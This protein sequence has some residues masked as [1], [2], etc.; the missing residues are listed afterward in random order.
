MV[1]DA[2]GLEAILR[3]VIVSCRSCSISRPYFSGTSIEGP[4]Y[5]GRRP[6]IRVEAAPRR[7]KLAASGVLS[8]FDQ[9]SSANLL[10]DQCAKRRNTRS[11]PTSDSEL[12]TPRRDAHTNILP[13]VWPS[14]QPIAT[15]FDPT[16]SQMQLA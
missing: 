6:G 14:R 8:S 15:Y 3:A 9:Y 12:T 11:A 10:I 1:D 4:I 7:T 2:L 13:P 5:R 16:M